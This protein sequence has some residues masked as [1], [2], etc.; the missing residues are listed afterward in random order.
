MTKNY[1]NP[2]IEDEIQLEEE[3]REEAI[4]RVKDIIEKTCAEGQANN[5]ILGKGMINYG[6]NSLVQG[7][8]AFVKKELKPK[9]GVVSN[10]HSII[11][12]L[13]DIY[14]DDAEVVSLLTLSTISI[15]INAVFTS[16]KELNSV[17]QRIA[18]VIED[19]A[20]LQAYIVSKPD[21]LSEFTEGFKRR[22]GEHFKKYYAMNKAMKE[23]KFHWMPFDNTGKRALAGKLIELLIQTTNLFTTETTKGG[24]KINTLTTIVPTQHFIDTWNTNEMTMLGHC[25]RSIP[26]IVKPKPWTSYNEGGYYGVLAPFYMLLRILKIKSVFYYNYM[27]KLEQTD[28]SKVTRAINAVQATPW[29]INKK[30]LSVVEEIVKLGGDIGGIP[31]VEPLPEL[32]NLVGDYTDKELK[33]HKKK[34]MNRIKAENRR[35]AKMM[36]CLS[37]LQIAQKYAPYHAI[38]FPCNMDF[39]GRVYP[40]PTFSFQGD[41]F[42]KGLLLMQDTPPCTDEKAEYWFRIAGCEFFGNDKVSFDDQIKWTHDNEEAILSVAAD[43]L[44]EARDFWSNSDCPIEFLGWCFA[45]EEM[46]EYKKTHNN[47]VI[48]W[49]CGVPVAFDGTCSGWNESFSPYRQ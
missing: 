1:L 4:R 13:K 3:A 43:P 2:S 20:H 15:C 33:E 30:V 34:K 23:A 31:R 21:N 9:C 6:F 39:R 47:S 37:M 35:K 29:T 22:C 10:Y 24:T 19:E 16:H 12:R 14:K 18:T 25:Y 48:G 7:V 26:M 41:D 36:R 5:N 11:A 49:T 27:H 45:Y 17:A 32:P 42:T 38:Y 44:G 40:I 28:L 46:M 8:D